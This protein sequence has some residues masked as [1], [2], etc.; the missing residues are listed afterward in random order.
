MVRKSR[1]ATS[2]CK[3]LAILPFVYIKHM[4]FSNISINFYFVKS[5]QREI[6]R[7]I[8]LAECIVQLCYGEL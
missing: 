6:T 8:N 2:F 7:K 5:E 3:C 1:S 4:Y